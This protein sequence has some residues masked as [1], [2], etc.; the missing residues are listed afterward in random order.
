MGGGREREMEGYWRQRWEERED[1]EK[2]TQKQ[3]VVNLGLHRIT[4]A[5]KNHTT[6]HNM[7]VHL[8]AHAHACPTGSYRHGLH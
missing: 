6:S 1:R 8:H 5:E 3:G 2:N 4:T 7:H